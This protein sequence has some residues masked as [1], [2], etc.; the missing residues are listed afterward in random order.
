MAIRVR[1]GTWSYAGAI[2]SC[3]VWAAADEREVR[4]LRLRVPVEAGD[5]AVLAVGAGGRCEAAGGL[6]V[7]LV[8]RH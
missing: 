5:E 4:H 2:P 8:V 3:Y 1:L 6:V 7:A